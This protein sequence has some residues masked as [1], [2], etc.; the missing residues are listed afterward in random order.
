MKGKGFKEEQITRLLHAAERDLTVGE[1][2]R[3]HN[4][5]E[6]SF[7]RWKAK[8]GGMEVSDVKRLPIHFKIHRLPLSRRYGVVLSHQTRMRRHQTF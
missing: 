5:S 7:Y 2:C 1:V 4:C 3:Q 6:Q 8:F